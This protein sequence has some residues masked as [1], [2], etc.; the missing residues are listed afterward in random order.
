M[1]PSD[2]AHVLR[3]LSVG[4]HPDLLVGLQTADDAAVWR[5]SADRALVQTV[6]FFTPIVDDAY[7]YGAIAAANS[8]SD[9]YAMGGEPFLALAI[10]AFP[11][12]LPRDLLGEIGRGA[13]DKAAEA[14]VVIAGGHTVVDAEPKYGLC[15][16]GFVHPERI[17]TKGAARP[18]DVL[19]LTKPLGT[20]VI[21]TALKKERAAPQHVAGA[22][23]SMLC[24]NR[25]AARLLGRF[26]EVRACTDVTGFGLLG[27]AYEMASAS[28]AG[29]EIVAAEV[30]FLPG[31]LDYVAAD[32]LPG[33]ADRNQA[34]LEERDA[35]GA[36]RVVFLGSASPGGAA[37]GGPGVDPV[38][39]AALFDPQTSG[40]LLFAAPEGI[41][42]GVADAFREAGHPL[43]RVGRCVAGR[44]V[45][46]T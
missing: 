33:G 7:T 44:G 4:N 10:A 14:G 22:V 17:L 19:F 26:P 28:G 3:H 8:L 31:A 36:P 35:S 43:W 39:A 15:V 25:A 40:G 37:R 30:P 12:D 29:L 23:E 42:G 13:R 38:R 2:L 5:L 21:A 34:Y 32:L 27:H 24:L 1:G 46:V 16:S 45:T 11:D 6:D 9:V 41:A 18:G 20:G